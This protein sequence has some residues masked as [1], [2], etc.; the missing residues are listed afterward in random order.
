M[1]SPKPRSSQENYAAWEAA[2]PLM[3]NPFILY[4]LMIFAGGAWF[5]PSLVI[6][7]GLWLW[8]PPSEPVP[9]LELFQLMA[10]VV[11]VF[12][13]FFALVGLTLM[14]N[15]FFARYVLNGSGVSYETARGVGS[16]LGRCRYGGLRPWGISSNEVSYQASK[17]ILWEKLQV[18]REHPS[19]R[20]ISLCSSVMPVVRLYCPDQETYQRAL[21]LCREELGRRQAP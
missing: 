13:A 20:V 9:V 14:G 6:S 17:W 5:F 3:T 15:R 12:L 21:A 11:L 19:W 18:I 10:L 8:L 4:D 16:G 1:C 2:V 7:L